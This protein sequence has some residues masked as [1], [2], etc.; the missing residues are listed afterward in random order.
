MKEYYLVQLIISIPLSLSLFL[1]LSRKIG[2]LRKSLIFFF[3][4]ERERE[5]M[6][7][8]KGMLRVNFI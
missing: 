4:K 5:R 1:A 2:E 3:H 7:R 8:K 6:R